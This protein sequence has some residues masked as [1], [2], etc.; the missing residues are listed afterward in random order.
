MLSQLNVDNYI[1]LQKIIFRLCQCQ[2]RNDPL[3]IKNQTSGPP[4]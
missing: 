3:L 1:K 2:A 4:Q